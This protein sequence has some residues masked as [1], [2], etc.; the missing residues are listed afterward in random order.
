MTSAAD[1]APALDI[2]ARLVA[3]DT[4]SRE[5]NLA[6]IEW[7]E[8]FL[9]QRGVATTRV[10]SADGRKSNLHALIGPAVEGGVVLSGHTDVVP[11]DGQPWTS[12]PWTVAERDGRLYGRGVADMKS[13][14]ALALAHVDAAIA[15]PLKRPIILA[16][17]YDE[18][19]GCLGLPAPAAVIVG[20]PTSMR[21][22]SGH[23]GISTFTVTVGGREAHSSQTQQGVS[24][25]MEALPLM[26]LVA[27]MAREAE[28]KADQ[29]SPFTPPQT[30]MTVGMVSGGTAVNILARRC[31]FVWDL[32]CPPDDDP[33]RYATRFMAAAQAADARIKVRA[34]E[35]GV[36]VVRRSSTPALR[37]ERD[38]D[39][40]RL[41]RAITGDNGVEAAGYAAEGGLFQ[42]AGWATVIC[43]PGSIAQAH[44][45]DE[46]IEIDQ[47]AQGAR[48]L[49]KLVERLSA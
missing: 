36:T 49:T 13:F 45:P 15:A 34:P 23:K 16:F 5:S 2:L 6:L 46:W 40:E 18:E 33:E 3:F 44:Q 48:F 22:V 25:V 28:G 4:T 47:I 37:I 38:S 29:A 32:R 27:D 9:A 17:S 42:R 7:V 43:G 41:A 11:V 21:V 35:G 14:V 24:A 26:Q 19:V 12:D 30:T 20:E 1:I 31:E 10:P 8:A 39:A